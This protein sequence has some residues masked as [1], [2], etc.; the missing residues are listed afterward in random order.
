[1]ARHSPDLVIS[2]AGPKGKGV[3]AA[4]PIPPGSTVATFYGRGKLV[5]DI[6]QEDWP[7]A[8]Q[9]DY[10]R[11]VVPERQGAGWYINHSCEPNCFI[12][13]RSVVTARAIRRGEELTFDYSTDVDWPGFNM[14]CSCGASRCRRA[15][16]AYRYLP[17]GEK[18][19]Y[20][21]SVAPYI[22]RKYRPTARRPR[23]TAEDRQ[24]P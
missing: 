18:A 4:A 13:G 22:S 9:V 2:G 24:T 10:D 8:F 17:E 6:P 21:G 1:M 3:F 5:W 19:K 15:V 7:Y 23:R 11:Y 16:R 14:P 12:S 20:R